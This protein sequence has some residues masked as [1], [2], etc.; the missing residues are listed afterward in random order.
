M[1]HFVV[2]GALAMGSFAAVLLLIPPLRR[3]AIARGITD[4]PGPRKLHARP[5]P[6]LGGVALTL[7]ALVASAFLQGWSAEALVILGGAA[8]V[9]LVGLIDD[10]RTLAP[11]LRLAVECAA[12][13]MAAA[14][15]ARV[16]LFGGPADWAITVA[17]L[18]VI[19][20]AFNLLDNMDGAAGAIAAITATALT[21][22]AVLGSQWLVASLAAVVAGSCLGFLQ[23]NWH[24]ARIFM[25]DAG[26]LFLGYLLAVI[27]L[28][29]RFPVSHASS[30]LAVILFTGP[31]L[32]DTTLVV[33]AR[34]REGR[35]IYLGSTDHVAH[36]L[37]QRG[38]NPRQVASLLALVC[39][40][41]SVLGGL[42]GRGVIPPSPV[43]LLAVPSTL[44]TLTGLLRLPISGAGRAASIYV[45]TQDGT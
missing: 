40:G 26:S 2:I 36:R 45:A 4:V 18:V 41:C 25:G 32:F 22:M 39:G 20:N 3:V 19:T 12:A 13:L 16:H 17:W 31:A 42:V 27:A 11:L 15:G 24:P 33:I 7:T 8:L 1:N 5:T 14:A 23:Y 38:M 21:G 9:S 44:L 30:I 10:V 37:L 6:Y 35:P 28:K 34:V 43:I 29:L